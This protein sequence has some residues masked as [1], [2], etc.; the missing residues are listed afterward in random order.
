MNTKGKERQ[1]KWKTNYDE[2]LEAHPQI[3]FIS[4]G[5]IIYMD[6]NVKKKD[7]SI[8]DILSICDGI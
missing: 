7:T 8:E 3:L 1:D 2:N 4:H 6:R 5:G